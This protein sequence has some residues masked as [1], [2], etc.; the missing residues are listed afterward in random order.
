VS[1]G[2][3]DRR[4][5]DLRMSAEASLQA[6]QAALEAGEWAAARDAFEAALALEPGAEAMA[7]LGMALWWLEEPAASLKYRESAYAEFRRRPDPFQAALVALQL[8][9]H[10]GASL[11]NLAAAQ[12]WLGR[13]GRLVEE[14]DLAPLRGWVMLCRAALANA[15]D[16]P[17]TAEGLARQARELAGR[18]QD[19]DLELCALSELGGTLVSLGRVAE[20]TALLDEAMAGALGGE[21][22]PNTVVYTS[23]KTVVSCSR[24]SELKRA[25]Q[26]IRAADTFNQ[27]YGSAHLYALCRTHHGA[28]LLATG[29]WAEAEREL[30]AALAVSSTAE[31]ALHAEA[32]TQLAQLRLAQGRTD[33]ASRL[34]EGLADHPGAT[35]ALA[36]VRLRRGEFGSAAAILRRRIRAVGED[37]VQGA[38]LLGLLIEVELAGGDVEAARTDAD[39]LAVL[40]TEADSDV[41]A[42]LADRARGCVLLAAGETE[43]AGPYLERS[44]AEYARLEMPL[45]AG[46]ARLVLARAL[47]ASEREAAVGEARV[48]LASFEALGAGHD[49]DAA[50]AFLRSL[51]VKAARAGQRGTGVLT[52]RELEILELLGEGLSNRAMAERLVLTRKTVENHVANVLAKLG[53][54]GRAEAAAF[55]V[56]HLDS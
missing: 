54:S 47:P 50:A 5:Y 6:G 42:A 28:V 13:A 1:S 48:A 31:P 32:L 43:A 29:R 36:T 26:W 23:C 19:A 2:P 33:A 44:L 35:G 12:G 40:R 16:D 21:G 39:R 11:G 53:L 45:E 3:A 14:F 17:H 37:S 9:P 22:G 41:L 15:G 25:V 38:T 7:G 46:R 30:Q 34:L 52:K 27:R 8:C 55:A 4:A 51:G 20:G 18:T 24:A 56:R 49:A 10:Y